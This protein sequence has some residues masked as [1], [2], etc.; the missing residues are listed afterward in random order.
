MPFKKAKMW[1]LNR[2]E[3]HLCGK[4]FFGFRKYMRHII[5]IPPS[6]MPVH[7]KGGHWYMGSK[8]FKSKASAEKAHRAYQAKKHAK[9]KKK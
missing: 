9:R 4:K 3:C 2:W 5:D 8:K 6:K 1:S 7:K